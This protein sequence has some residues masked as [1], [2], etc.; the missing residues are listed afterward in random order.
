[1][2]SLPLTIAE[3]CVYLPGCVYHV[4]DLCQLL[5]LAPP[6]VLLL[7]L[8]CHSR[9]IVRDCGKARPGTRLQADFIVRLT[10]SAVSAC[11]TMPL[12][13]V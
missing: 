11:E 8:L 1:M 6:A 7:V 2:P 3:C 13:A 9:D 4:V 5:W 12:E 10:G